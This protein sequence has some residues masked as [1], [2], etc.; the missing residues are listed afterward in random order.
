MITTTNHTP[1]PQAAFERGD[2]EGRS[3][4]VVTLQGSFSLAADGG[5]LCPL[6]D[7]EGIQLVDS[8][9]AEPTSSSI[10]RAGVVA[11]RKPKSDVTV[12][13]AA[14]SA[15]P[16]AEW[17]VRL[18]VGLLDS[19]LKVRGPH[20]WHRDAEGW[21][22]TAP[23]P[24]TSVA[25]VYENAFGGGGRVGERYVDEPRNPLGTGYLPKGHEAEGPR[26]A[27]QVM[28]VDD[29]DFEVGERGMP[30]GWGA[31]PSY[32]APRTDH[33][34][35]CDD[36]WLQNRW[37]CP[38]KDFDDAFYQCAHPDLIYPGY[39]R[40]DESFCVDG[41]TVSGEPVRGRLPG[42]RMLGLVRLRHGPVFGS[43]AHLD[44]AH[45]D[46]IHP[47]PAQHRAYLTWRCLVPHA[48]DVASV[49]MHMTRLD[50]RCAA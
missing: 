22:R 21:R 14:R 30:R 38:P 44:H 27:P 17:Q 9:W 1:W 41:V 5:R 29:P 19:R 2:T 20:Y 3:F 45:F 6:D 13:A 48:E 42:W 16:R 32:F 49:D 28:S 43:V 23:E 39:L 37:P 8:F 47:D 15:V 46:L 18:R 31:I 24:C 4:W 7:Q 25:L 36:E 40:G 33:V 34:G 10:K 35:T 11:F 26:R 50:E 12:N